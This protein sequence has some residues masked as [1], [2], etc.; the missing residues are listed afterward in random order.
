ML[1]N[2]C[3]QKLNFLQINARISLVVSQSFIHNLILKF[4]TMSGQ[5]VY[6]FIQ[7]DLFCREKLG[8]VWISI[9][10]SSRARQN[11]RPIQFN[12]NPRRKSFTFFFNPHDSE[13]LICGATAGRAPPPRRKIPIFL[14]AKSRRDPEIRRRAAG[15]EKFYS[16]S[17][18]FLLRCRDWDDSLAI[19]PH[20]VTRIRRFSQD[21]A[22][23]PRDSSFR[24]L[25]YRI[26]RDRSPRGRLPP[27]PSRNLD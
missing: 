7:K 17:F 6:N 25:F 2:F 22:L 11:S 18:F 10:G 3:W 16:L 15:I 13:L 5:N 4:P 23:R 1:P 21:A 9:R 14:R 8:N 12:S 26:R 20:F 24:G 27:S 19:K